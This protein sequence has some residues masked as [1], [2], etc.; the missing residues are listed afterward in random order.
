MDPQGLILACC[1]LYAVYIW[2]SGLSNVYWN[3]VHFHAPAYR[4]IRS[5]HASR[6]TGAAT[7]RKMKC[8]RL[9]RFRRCRHDEKAPGRP[10]HP[11]RPPRPRGRRDRPPGRRERPQAPDRDRRLRRARDGVPDP[12]EGGAAPL[13]LGGHRPLRCAAAQPGHRPRHRGN[14]AGGGEAAAAAA[15]PAGEHHGAGPR[16]AG[17]PYREGGR[18]EVQL[19]NPARAR[20]AGVEGG[21]CLFRP[22]ERG[23]KLHLGGEDRLRRPE[24]GE[25]NEPRRDR[26]L[27]AGPLDPHGPGRGAHEGGHLHRRPV[28]EGD[29]VKGPRRIGRAGEGD[30]RRGDLRDP[31]HRDEAL[32]RSGGR[33]DP[34]RPLR[35]P[36]GHVGG[37]RL[38]RSAAAQ[39]RHRPRHGGESAGGG[40]APAVAGPAGGNHGAG[41]RE[42]CDP[43]RE[44]CRREVQLR[45]PGGRSEAGGEAEGGRR[46]FRA[47]EGGEELRFGGKGRLRRPEDGRRNELRRDRPLRAGPLDPHGPGCGAH[48]E[49]LLHRRPVHEGDPVEGPRRIGRTGEGDGRR[50]DLRYP[51]L[52]DEALRRRRYGGGC[53]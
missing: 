19:R 8:I 26:P 48:E 33:G 24:S 1:R 51:S 40:E 23:E 43:D 5:P 18:R 25:R 42:A 34:H 27:R 36:D 7:R 41:H 20:E 52:H 28:R 13:P 11:G 46:P 16:K 10:R 32:R 6:L 21:R 37:N 14:A 47:P 22:P 2:R 12:R 44:G 3:S 38:L 9:S 4:R 49:D 45:N 50:G 30:R 53:P 29:P 39:T 17:D 15:G 35:G 31:P